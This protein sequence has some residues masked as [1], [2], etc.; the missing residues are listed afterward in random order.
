MENEQA[1][2]KDIKHLPLHGPFWR[3]SAPYSFGFALRSLKIFGS[4]A[5]EKNKGD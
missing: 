3:N 5:G 1:A 4:F 2:P